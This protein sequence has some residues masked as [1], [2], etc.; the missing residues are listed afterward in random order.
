MGKRE[1]GDELIKKSD[2]KQI[3]VSTTELVSIYQTNMTSLLPNFLRLHYLDSGLGSGLGFALCLGLR[4]VFGWE[5]ILVFL[6][7][8]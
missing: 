8:I 3:L 7:T 6:P 5:F 2:K 1:Q 4:T